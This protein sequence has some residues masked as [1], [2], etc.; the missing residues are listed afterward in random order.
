MTN[1]TDP[2]KAEN[3]LRRRAQRQDLVLR[4]SRSRHPQAYET[5][6]YQLVNA[7]TN[8]LAAWGGPSGFSLSLDDIEVALNEDYQ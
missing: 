5:G 8:T 7:A 6:T 2:D 3:R 1:T 4:K